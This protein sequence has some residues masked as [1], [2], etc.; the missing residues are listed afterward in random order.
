MGI[1]G[2]E[3]DG[4]GDAILVDH[5]VVLGALLAAI[6]GISPCLLAPLLARTPSESTLARLQSIAT[7]SPN[8]LRSVSCSCG[9]TPA[10][11]QSRSRR[12]HVVPLPQPSS[13]GSSRQGQPVFRMNTMPP[14]AAR[15]GIRGRPPFGFGGSVG[16]K[17]SMASQS[18]SE[19]SDEA[20]KTRHHAIPPRV[21]NT[22]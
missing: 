18:S 8:Q 15:L 2:R 14:S 5:E 12:Q 22:L 6:R 1:G 16:N 19:T 4:E 17:G 10:T 20:F 13:L 9:Q 21:C 11:C 7:S 3:A